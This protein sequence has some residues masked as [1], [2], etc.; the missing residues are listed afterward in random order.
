MSFAGWNIWKNQKGM[1]AAEEEAKKSGSTTGYD[2]NRPWNMV[3][4]KGVV[5]ETY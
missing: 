5:D 2:D 4:Q 1:Q 3:F